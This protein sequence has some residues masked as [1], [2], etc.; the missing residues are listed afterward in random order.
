[1]LRKI[2]A[3]LIILTFVGVVFA[4]PG[5]QCWQ[6][7]EKKSEI[8]NRASPKK[9]IDWNM[10]FTGLLPKIVVRPTSAIIIK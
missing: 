7:A 9:L 4:S 5:G 10:V 6:P 8:F 2:A 3:V 1:M